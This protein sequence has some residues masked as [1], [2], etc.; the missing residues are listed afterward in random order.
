MWRD[1]F[2]V[3]VRWRSLSEPS[4]KLLW[5][6]NLPKEYAERL[7][8]SSTNMYYFGKTNLR[9]Q[10][11]VSRVV[12]VIVRCILNNS[13]GITSI[14]DTT[15]NMNP[16]YSLRQ[17]TPLH[18]TE[19]QH[20]D[21]ELLLKS[22]SRDHVEGANN[23]FEITSV[24]LHFLNHLF[25]I[26]KVCN[27]S[28][29]TCALS[30]TAHVNTGLKILKGAGFLFETMITAG[31]NDSMAYR[32]NKD[33]IDNLQLVII[34]SYDLNRHRILSAELA[35]AFSKTLQVITAIKVW[36]NIFYRCN[37]NFDGE[38][39]IWRGRVWNKPGGVM[40][41]NNNSNNSGSDD[42][43]ECEMYKSIAIDKQ[44]TKD[45]LL[46]GFNIN[47]DD[48]IIA[49]SVKQLL[50]LKNGLLDVALEVA[51]YWHLLNPLTRGTAMLG[52]MAVISIH[53]AAGIELVPR[54]SNVAETASTD[55]AEYIHSNI[56]MDLEA[57][58]AVDLNQFKVAMKK[59]FSDQKACSASL[60]NYL[61]VN[62]NN[63]MRHIF[64]TASHII[65]VLN[66]K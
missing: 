28:K 56:Q 37:V 52:Y 1:Y 40:D 50:T 26:E 6:D 5:V 48:D 18:L 45:C 24:P 15:N 57:I 13:Y 12:A 58:T 25:R 61:D 22:Y 16:N 63:Q 4:D 42:R 11:Y 21:I 2:Q 27:I 32:L 8:G 34:S 38:E 41:S 49:C 59:V 65:S 17:F 55:E 46:G 10:R 36:E 62:S 14:A 29:T 47:S 3:G 64:P 60:R 33:T 19:N 43:N 31:S 54:T 51:F 30:S 23:N 9:Y 53:L 7:T 44:Y 20:V 66:E 39:Y 35:V